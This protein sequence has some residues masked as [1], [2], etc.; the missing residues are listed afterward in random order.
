M[1]GLG[2]DVGVCVPD[3]ILSDEAT[4][5]AAGIVDEDLNVGLSGGAFTLDWFLSGATARGAVAGLCLGAWGVGWIAGGALALCG[6]FGCPCSGEYGCEGVGVVV[7][8]L[9]MM[10][11]CW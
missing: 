8:G 4:P 11:C 6:P 3:G 1:P 9:V 5:A 7:A 2:A 10:G